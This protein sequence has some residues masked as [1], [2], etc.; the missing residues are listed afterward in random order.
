MT[1]EKKSLEERISDYNP[2]KVYLR[3]LIN[4]DHDFL[5]AKALKKS[6][7]NKL[8][9]NIA[10]EHILKPHEGKKGRIYLK[11]TG[12]GRIDTTELLTYVAEDYPEIFKRYISN[13]D[14]LNSFTNTS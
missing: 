11:P 8:E 13:R 10:T 1:H 4:K 3:Y 2:K 5:M 12:D 6:N 14:K 7:L 9:I